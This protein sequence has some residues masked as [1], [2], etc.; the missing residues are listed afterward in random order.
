[1]Y[2]CGGSSGD[3]GNPGN[4]PQPYTVTA[5]VAGGSLRL[6]WPK[7]A[8]GVVYYQAIRNAGALTRDGMILRPWGNPIPAVYSTYQVSLPIPSSGTV[9]YRIRACNTQPP[10]A[11]Q[12]PLVQGYTG[13]RDSAEF[14]AGGAQSGQATSFCPRISAQS[15]VYPDFVLQQ[16]PTAPYGLTSAQCATFF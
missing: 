16:Y 5:S 15:D 2:G 6:S 12:P 10:A 8:T 11:G 1:V 4:P 9:Y 7:H 14:V 3:G 13:C